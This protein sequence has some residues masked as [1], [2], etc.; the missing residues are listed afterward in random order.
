MQNLWQQFQQRVTR[1]QLARFGVSFLLA[2][3]L[4]G[5]VTQLQD[6]IETRRFAELTIE[7]PE[8]SGTIEIVTALPRVDV[9][10]TDVES[11]LEGLS[12]ADIRVSLDVSEIEGAGTFQVPVEA[13][14]TTGVRDIEVSPDTISIQVEEE[15]SENFPLTELTVDD[16]LLASDAR[17]VVDI[18]P[19]I[20]QVTVRGTESA[21][22]RVDRVMLPV[23][24]DGQT[25]DFMILIEPY[26]VDEDNQRIQEVTIDPGQVRTFVEMETRGKTVSVVPQLS[27]APADGFV[28]QQQISLPS[29]IIVDGPEEALNPI[30]FINTEP[31]DIAG[32]TQS[33]SRTVELEPLPEGV[34]LVEPTDN[35]VEVRV[36]IG[37]SAGSPSLIQDM[38]VEVE[39]LGDGLQA[40][41]DPETI[42]LSVTGSADVLGSL[43]PEDIKVAVDVAGLGVGV[44]TLTPEVTLPPDVSLS[45]LDPQ[46]VTVLIS[47][48]AT[49]AARGQPGT[50]GAAYALTG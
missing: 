49:P 42:D 31:V 25:T 9:S 17:R 28:V 6:P 26:A 48:E 27:G 46:S 19:E 3:L 21:V 5:W 32:A 14:T 11:R 38:P 22:E 29:T 47:A 36:S 24:I 23:A 2:A 41:V 20:S 8:M 10:V 33:L 40:T 37:T 7:E 50:L 30:L 16:E 4:W 34:T 15:I 39:N 13:S 1:N 35:Q 44:Y 45:L 12:R 43:T 18:N